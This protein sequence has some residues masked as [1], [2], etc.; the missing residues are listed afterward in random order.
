MSVDKF[1]VVSID[2]WRYD[3]LSRSNALFNTPKFDL[4][5]RDYALAERYFVTAPATRPS[6]SSLFTGL[7]PFEHGLLGQ[8][9]LKMFAGIDNLFGVFAEAGYSAKGFSER[10]DV[11]RFLDFEPFIGPVDGEVKNQ[12]LGSLER[13]AA[14]MIEPDDRPQF[15]FLHFWYTHGGYGLGGIPDGPDLRKL[16]EKGQ[17]AEALR[18]YYAAVNHVLEFS[19]VELLKKVNLDEWAIFICGDHGEGFCDEVMAHGDRLHPNVVHVPMLAHVPG[20]FA[21]PERGPVSSIDLLPTIT[22]LAGIETAYKGYGRSWL[23]AGENFADRW[24]LSELD[25]LYGVG[26]LSA[27]NLQLDHE[28]VTSR[29]AVDDSEIDRYD[30]G[31][32]EWCLCDGEQFYRQNEQSVEFVLR[33]LRD[34]SDLV[35]EDP[36]AY[37]KR[38]DA[39]VDESPY[40]NMQGQESSSDEALVLEKRLRDLGYI[41]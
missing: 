22:E 18:Y 32:R 3:A 29:T 24:V 11:F 12:H 13:L 41:E 23:G 38:Y 1:L 10:A 28:R 40:K 25:S 33:D 2:C 35:C 9:Y 17:V 19:L 31:I 26:F 37:R 27:K 6:H 36:Q 16:V 39:L 30:K 7:Y 15:K 21:F 5:T 20:G 14:E 8:T 4:L 34:G